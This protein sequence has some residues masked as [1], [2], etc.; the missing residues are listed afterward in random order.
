MSTDKRCEPPCCTLKTGEYYHNWRFFDD[1]TE[2]QRTLLSGFLF[3]TLFENIVCFR[4]NL[5]ARLF[6]VIQRD[7]CW[8]IIHRSWF[9]YGLLPVNFSWDGRIFQTF[10]TQHTFQVLKLLKN[11]LLCQLPIWKK[12]LRSKDILLAN[13]MI[14]SGLIISLIHRQGLSIWH[15]ERTSLLAVRE[16]LSHFS[17]SL[18]YSSRA[19]PRV[20]VHIKHLIRP[21]S[22][23]P[24]WRQGER[25]S[26]PA[27][28]LGRPPCMA[29]KVKLWLVWISHVQVKISIPHISQSITA[30]SNS[31]NCHE[32]PHCQKFLVTVYIVVPTN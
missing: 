20:F 15:L 8:L 26:L 2:F 6:L 29:P 27:C 18:P 7:K 19:R 5:D 17:S 1:E 31:G 21:C 30:P 32:F 4:V 23:P 14:I 22:G 12:A 13:N 3:I 10:K 9:E 16:E 11:P 25:A 24:A 28:E